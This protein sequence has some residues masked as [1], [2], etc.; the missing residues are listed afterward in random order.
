MMKQPR[1]N[2]GLGYRE[3]GNYKFKKSTRRPR[4]IISRVIPKVVTKP[5]SSPD[6]ISTISTEDSAETNNSWDKQQHARIAIAQ[7]F[8]NS[9]HFPPAYEDEETVEKIQ[10]IFPAFAKSTISAVINK[11]RNRKIKM[12]FL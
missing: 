12:I 9:L 4:R 1:R 10:Q 8:I 7:V 2:A 6:R 5:A 11:T 3:K